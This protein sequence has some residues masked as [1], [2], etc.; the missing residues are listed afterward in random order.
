M[1]S[2][3]LMTVIAQTRQ[4][5]RLVAQTVIKLLGEKLRENSPNITQSSLS[6]VSSIS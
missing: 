4:V 2:E 3:R 1:F 5:G 6:C